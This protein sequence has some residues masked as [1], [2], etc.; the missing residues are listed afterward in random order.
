MRAFAPVS[1]VA[2]AVAIVLACSA[3]ASTA[4]PSGLAALHYSRL[5]TAA[6]NRLRV[7][8]AGDVFAAQ[9]GAP[10][11][12][13]YLATG[14]SGTVVNTFGCGIVGGDLLLGGIDESGPACTSV[15]SDDATA[16]D[17]FKPTI[18]VLM[19][20][21]SEVL[22]RVVDGRQLR[23]GSKALEEYLDQRLDSVR[24]VLTAQGAKLV[25]TTVP[26]MDPPHSGTYGFLAGYQSDPA[27]VAWVNEVWHRYADAHRG[28]VVLADLHGLLCNGTAPR[29]SAGGQRLVGSSGIGFSAVGATTT[30]KWL[31][32]IATQATGRTA[33]QAFG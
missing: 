25:L 10:Y 30:W 26:C 1:V 4:P 6:G 7:L 3:P 24:R 16:V 31:A 20:G 22:D 15:P 23:V 18:V 11:P 27:R 19:V 2:A 12:N 29:V 9:L 33:A 28:S 8:V 17:A 5:A 32:R 21:S 14:I 13:G